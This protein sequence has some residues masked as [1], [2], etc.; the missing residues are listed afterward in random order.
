MACPHLRHL[1]DRR[2]VTITEKPS[3]C[4]PG[5]DRILQIAGLHRRIPW[6]GCSCM[7][8]GSYFRQ[9]F[10]TQGAKPAAPVLFGTTELSGVFAFATAKAGCAS[11]PGPMVNSQGFKR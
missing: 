4:G 11:R 6:R 3:G 9:N 8:I 2:A 5:L 1:P 7:T 10:R